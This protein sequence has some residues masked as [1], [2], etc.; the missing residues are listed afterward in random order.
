MA[1]VAPNAMA[2]HFLLAQN[3]VSLAWE[4]AERVVDG[5]GPT[6][7]VQLD[8]ELVNNFPFYNSKVS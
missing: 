1:K 2:T 3:E 6:I 5:G 8:L 7:S 4:G